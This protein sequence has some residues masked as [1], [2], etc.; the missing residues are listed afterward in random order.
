MSALSLEELDRDAESMADYPPPQC[1]I[2]RV[3][4]ATPRPTTEELR[5]SWDGHLRREYEKRG[6]PWRRKGRAMV[7]APQKWDEHWEYRDMDALDD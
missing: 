5:A 4:R 6:I 2:E 7:Y 1:A 3:E